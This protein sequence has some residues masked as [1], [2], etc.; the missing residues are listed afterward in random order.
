[1]TCNFWYRNLLCSTTLES[2]IDGI[3]VGH[4]QNVQSCVTKK[5]SNLKISVK[6]PRFNKRRAFNKVVGPGKKSKNN[7]HR[8]YVYSGL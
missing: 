4:E 3:S 6:I 7:K 5:P 2:G 1:M 8:A